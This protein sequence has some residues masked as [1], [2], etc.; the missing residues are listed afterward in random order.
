MYVC[1]VWPA[2]LHCTARQSGSKASTVF[3]L[4]P[5]IYMYVYIYIYC[6]IGGGKGGRRWLGWLVAVLAQLRHTLT[7]SHG[8]EKQQQQQQQRL[9]AVRP[10]REE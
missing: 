5:E 6:I 3:I 8:D 2:P 10:K 4:L 1:L 7:L 9:L